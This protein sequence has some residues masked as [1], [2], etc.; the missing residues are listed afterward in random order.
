MFLEFSSGLKV[1]RLLG[2]LFSFTFFYR[3][4]KMGFTKYM[5]DDRII[6]SPL[7]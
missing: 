7:E 4:R 2:W 6:A 3:K 5:R 1:N